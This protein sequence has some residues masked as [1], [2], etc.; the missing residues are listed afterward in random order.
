MAY[1][2]DNFYLRRDSGCAP[3]PVVS[4]TFTDKFPYQDHFWSLD[5][6]SGTVQ[7][8]FCSPDAL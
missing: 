8:H 7:G 2:I 3:L 1:E 5:P 6:C 4:I